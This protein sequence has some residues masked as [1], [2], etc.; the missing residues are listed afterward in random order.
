MNRIASSFTRLVVSAG[1]ALAVGCAPAA[2]EDPVEEDSA[3][4]GELS[5]LGP[6]AFRNTFAHYLRKDG[7]DDA[8]IHELVYLA[9]KEVTDPN[10]EPDPAAPLARL[11]ARFRGIRPSELYEHGVKTPM[12]DALDVERALASRPVHIVVLPGIF[13]EFIEVAPFE[14]VYQA[15]GSAAR[16]RWERLIAETGALPEATDATFDPKAVKEVPRS[17]SSLVRT[18]SIDD[19]SGRPLVTL[20]YMVPPLGSLESLGTLEENAAVYLRRLRKYFAILGVTDDVYVLGYSRGAATALEVVAQATSKPAE[21]PWTSKLRGVISLAGVLYGSQIADSARTKGTPQGDVLEVLQGLGNDLETC[22]VETPTSK[23]LRIQASN[24]GRWAAAVAKASFRATK[25][26]AHPE[27]AWE[28]IQSASPDLA[29]M[30]SFARRLLVDEVFTLANPLADYCPNVDR[31]KMTLKKTLQGIDSLTTE[32]RLDWWRTHTLPANI[33]YFALTGTMGD[34]TRQPGATW[35]HA[36][37]TIGYDPTS[38]DF[39]SLR[40]NYYDLL[41]A[42][43]I[44]ANDSQVTINRAKFW[45]NLMPLLNAKQQPLRTYFLGTVGSHHWG[46][47]FPRAFATKDGRTANPYPRTSLIHAIG[48]FVSVVA[49]REGS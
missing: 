8:A 16:V 36:Q 9:P 29:R 47:A 26:P 19:A 4:I 33:R 3:A 27:I 14:E 12:N 46:L 15:K 35:A 13:G 30:T 6:K 11:D 37:N 38:I 39:K 34:A 43:G 22:T 21:N 28:A 44:E 49:T 23:R 32:S 7:L 42:S 25:L 17:L 45:P 20:S 31:F 18:G 24:G 2:E 41:G 48:S 5:R 40:T 1:I 10:V